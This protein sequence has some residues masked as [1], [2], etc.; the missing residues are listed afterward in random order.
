MNRKYWYMW[1]NPENPQGVVARADE[2]SCNGGMSQKFLY[3]CAS[4]PDCLFYL[5]FGDPREYSILNASTFYGRSLANLMT[6]HQDFY[7]ETPKTFSEEELKSYVPP[8]RSRVALPCV[9]TDA[10]RKFVM[11]IIINPDFPNPA[12]VEDL[13]RLLPTE[14]DN[15]NETLTISKGRKHFVAGYEGYKFQYGDDLI[16]ALLKLL[17]W[18]HKYFEEN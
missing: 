14:L 2:L 16:T 18:V 12:T 5:D 7:E 11:S 3:E 9:L 13:I 6:S 15:D 17:V 10:E 1:G 4:N 8:V